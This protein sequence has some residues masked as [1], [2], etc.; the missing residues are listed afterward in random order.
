MLLTALAVVCG[1]AVLLFDPGFQG[2]AVSLVAG[3][4]ASLVISRMAVP[5]LYSMMARRRRHRAPTAATTIA[6]AA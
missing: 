3:E 6:A 2:L 4:I 1:A 5:V